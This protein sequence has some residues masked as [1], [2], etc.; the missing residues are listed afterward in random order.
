[1]PEKHRYLTHK[2][3]EKLMNGS[4]QKTLGPRL[5]GGSTVS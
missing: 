2:L 4:M 1:M 5:T 3:F